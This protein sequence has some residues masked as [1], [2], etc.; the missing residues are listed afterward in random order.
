V[1]CEPGQKIDE[2]WPLEPRWAYPESKV[3][4][5]ALLRG[6]HGDI[7]LAI[8]RIAG[9]YDDLCHSIPIANQIQ[10][11]HERRLT[12]RVFPGDPSRGQAFV[13]LED[14]V[15]ALELAVRMRAGLASEEV[16]LI[17]E[18][19]TPSYDELQRQIAWLIHGEDWETRS[20]PKALAK[21]GA[22]L[23]DNMPLTEEPF[24][25]P[26]MIDLADDH[27]ELDTGKARSILG[28]EPKRSLRETLPEMI[29]ALLA[30]PIG[31]YRENELKPS[32]E[33]E[34]AAGAA[35]KESDAG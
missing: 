9:V 14:L 17:G 12:A 10:R 29:S 25:K 3:K 31:W 19:E 20:I 5:E 18:D 16:F 24:I 4:T 1:P 32:A 27:Y 2:D 6:L 11:I 8:L 26:W 35:R 23:Q 13:H 21:T 28:W 7:P 15:D 30:D 33:I 22:W 34:E